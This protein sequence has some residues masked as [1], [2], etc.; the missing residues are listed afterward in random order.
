MPTSRAEV[1]RTGGPGE[2]RTCDHGLDPAHFIGHDERVRVALEVIVRQRLGDSALS[3]MVHAPPTV[4]AD[5]HL[6]VVAVAAHG[7]RHV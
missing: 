1:R 4:E 3:G 5:R 6:A 7:T 2:I